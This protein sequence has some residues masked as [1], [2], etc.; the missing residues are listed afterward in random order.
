MYKVYNSELPKDIIKLFDITSS[1]G[2]NLHNS[3]KY[4]V[5]CFNLDI[6]RTSLRYRGTLSWNFIPDALKQAQ[7]LNI[8]KSILKKKK[9]FN[10]K[11]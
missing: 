8:F 3:I 10:A 2:Y 6:G 5:P 9:N 4:N 7:N 11:H 1:H